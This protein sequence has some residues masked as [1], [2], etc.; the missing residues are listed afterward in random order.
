MASSAY[1]N[2]TTKLYTSGCWLTRQNVIDDSFPSWISSVDV[3]FCR[4]SSK[5]SMRSCEKTVDN[6]SLF[7]WENASTRFSESTFF[8]HR[9]HKMSVCCVSNSHRSQKVVNEKKLS[10]TSGVVCLQP[11]RQ[12]SDF[13][14]NCILQLGKW[15][16]ADQYAIPKINM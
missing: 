5:L 8:S 6:N 4:V 14:G 10:T 9:P 11:Q 1:Q 16:V 15:A 12:M 7:K 2:G 13:H 3:K